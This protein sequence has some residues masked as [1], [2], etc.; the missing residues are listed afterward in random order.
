MSVTK[1]GQKSML[2]TQIAPQESIVTV[3][4]ELSE[5]SIES[6]EQWRLFSSYR[7]ASR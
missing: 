5:C 2:Q 1:G 4:Y 6:T 3:F 7:E